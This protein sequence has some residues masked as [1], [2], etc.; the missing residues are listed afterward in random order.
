MAI[1]LSA[2]IF[3]VAILQVLGSYVLFDIYIEVVRP[4]KASLVGHHVLH[5]K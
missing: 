3:T 1:Q 5:M 2:R 4:A